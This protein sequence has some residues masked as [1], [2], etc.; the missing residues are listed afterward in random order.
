MI[1]KAVSLKLFKNM[2]TKHSILFDVNMS[3]KC[4]ASKLMKHSVF[5]I[6]SYRWLQ[7]LFPHS[8]FFLYKMKSYRQFLINDIEKNKLYFFYL[9]INDVTAVFTL[10]F[11]L[12]KSKIFYRTNVIEAILLIVVVV[13]DDY[14][15]RVSLIPYKQ[16]KSLDH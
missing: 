7:K 5:C 3:W 12:Q 13:Q 1:L 16:L 11:F 8:A 2:T 14:L 10:S 4:R 15:R 9:V 6:R